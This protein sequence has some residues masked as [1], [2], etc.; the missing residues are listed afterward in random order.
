MGFP[1]SDLLTV[2]GGTAQAFT[3]G[4]VY[5]KTAG[6]GFAVY[7]ATRSAWWTAGGV[8]GILGFP[9]GNTT[10]VGTGSVA[11]FEGGL[12]SVSPA[13]TFRVNGDILTAVDR[14]GGLAA[15]GLPIS[16]EVLVPGGTAQAFE[17]ASVYWSAS[18]GAHV[19]SGPLRS[20]WW[21]SGGVTGPYGFPTGDVTGTASAASIRFATGTLEWTAATGARFVAD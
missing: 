18:T 7:G 13:G 5:A 20:A 10:T 9:T 11:T 3:G 19:I 6:P 15:V 21:A 8:T 16:A 2:P 17:R 1:A 12:L 14:V 4:S